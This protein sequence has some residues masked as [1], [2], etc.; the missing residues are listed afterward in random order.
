MKI[1]LLWFSI[2]FVAFIAALTIFYFKAPSLVS[3]KVPNEW[4]AEE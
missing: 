3:F 1:K 4:Q 2:A